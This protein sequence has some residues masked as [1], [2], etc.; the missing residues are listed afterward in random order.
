MTIDDIVKV[1]MIRAN[2]AALCQEVV[3]CSFHI[4]I[5]GMCNLEAINDGR[6]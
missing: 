2:N 1:G 3:Q 4:V 5:A 6:T